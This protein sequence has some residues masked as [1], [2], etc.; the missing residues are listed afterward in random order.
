[1]INGRFAVLPPGEIERIAAYATF[2]IYQILNP[3]PAMIPY[4]IGDT[5]KVTGGPF[6]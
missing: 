6:Q 2:L 3:P 4:A 1:M 5:V